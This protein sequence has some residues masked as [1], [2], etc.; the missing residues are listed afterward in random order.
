M[1]A[2]RSGI[3]WQCLMLL[4]VIALCNLSMMC[5]EDLLE[6]RRQ[7]LYQMRVLRLT[8]EKAGNG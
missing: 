6:C 4:H 7:I 1:P 5:A 3:T 8:G 2:A